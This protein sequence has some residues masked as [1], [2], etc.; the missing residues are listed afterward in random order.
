MAA[1]SSPRVSVPQPEHKTKRFLCSP[2]A[3]PPATTFR[4]A[5]R[6][7]EKKQNLSNTRARCSHGGAVVLMSI[8][9]NSSSRTIYLWE[10]TKTTASALSFSCL[11][12]NKMM[13]ATVTFGPHKQHQMRTVMRYI[14]YE[15]ITSRSV[16]RVSTRSRGKSQLA[17]TTRLLNPLEKTT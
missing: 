13:M 17:V 5:S 1:K 15:E 10:E 7:S 16:I 11:V 8:D 6:F 12:W 4:K 9:S 2:E 14:Y 3:P